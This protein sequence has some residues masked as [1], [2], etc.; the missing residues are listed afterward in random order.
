MPADPEISGNSKQDKSQK[1]LQLDRSHLNLKKLKEKILKEARGNIHLTHRP[2]ERIT[3]N[4][5]LD[6]MQARR[7]RKKMFKI[8][9]E[10][11]DGN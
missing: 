5:S 9:K 11:L 6:I 3:V 2:T 10:K 7:G 8:F 1:R 4:C